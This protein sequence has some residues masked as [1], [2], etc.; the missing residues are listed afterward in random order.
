MFG[1]LKKLAVW[2]RL[3]VTYASVDMSSSAGTDVAMYRYINEALECYL[4]TM[5]GKA[6]LD[7]GCG[8]RYQ[9]TLLFQ[10]FGSSAVGID[11]DLVGPSLAFPTK[12]ARLWAS[13]GP[14]RALQVLVRDILGY[15]R[16]YYRALEHE[17]AMCLSFDQVDIRRMSASQMTFP[18]AT[19]DAVVSTLV[20]EHIV[21]VPGAVRELARVLKEHGL[22]YIIVHLYTSLSGGHHPAW[23]DAMRQRTPAFVQPWDHLRKNSSPVPVYLNKLRLRDYLGVFG[24]HFDILDLKYEYEHEQFLTPALERELAQY[25]RQELLCRRLHMIGRKRPSPIV[26]RRGGAAFL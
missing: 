20:F 18:D 16:A 25:T 23:V 8:Q 24:E 22:I 19:F 17:S 11:I 21:D 3:M 26:G 6:V 5:K 12:Y 2:I 15:D 13:D 9:L 4:G 14:R 10:T 1:G 7:V